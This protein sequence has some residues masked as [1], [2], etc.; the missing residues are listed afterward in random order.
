[1][2]MNLLPD[3]LET[4]DFDPAIEA[5][6]ELEEAARRMGLCG[7]RDQSILQR[8]RLPE[9]ESRVSLPE[10]ALRIQ[11]STALG[12][13]IGAVDLRPDASVNEL[14]AAA[15]AQTWQCALLDLPFGGAAGAIV[16]DPNRLS[17]RELK[18]LAHRYVGSLMLGTAKDV[19]MP[20][21]GCHEMVMDW[22]A[23][24][25][26]PGA[27]LERPAIAPGVFVLLRQILAERSQP[28]TG[29]RVAIQGFGRTGGSLAKSL[30]EA[31]A[32]I[33]ALSDL[34]GALHR[35][36]GLDVAV[37]GDYFH[38]QG[39]LLDC[40]EGEPAGNLDLLQA[41]CDVLILA[42][43]PHQV[44]AW[45]AGKIAASIVMEVEAHAV[46]SGA[47]AILEQ[48]DRMV[49]PALLARAGGTLAL[50]HQWMERARGAPPVN[51][52]CARLLRAWAETQ[53]AM[54]LFRVSVRQ[55]AMLAAIG[56]LAVA[57]RLE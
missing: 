11:H 34:S 12:P 40:P 2:N 29:S 49:I 31:G 55:G 35:D 16:C 47:A 21:R 4:E 54:R 37:V 52:D 3:T 8:L 50:Y 13:S 10:T 48:R 32:R 56:R 18:S 1:M 33:V 15:M 53:S 41:P 43:A 46:G 24:R 17:E 42:A 6:L 26:E 39:R 25:V 27:V 51:L 38:R 57:L 9:R 20:G 14:C 44:N 7:E 45:L 36:S 23:R 19:L 22:M 5:G 30:H 28:L